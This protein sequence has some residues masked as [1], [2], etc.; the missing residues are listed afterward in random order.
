MIGMEWCFSVTPVYIYDSSS[1]VPKNQ[2]SLNSFPEETGLNT[3]P[4]ADPYFPVT[5]N[6]KLKNGSY[7]WPL[8]HAHVELNLK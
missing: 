4:V 7:K 1:I 8:L 5:M 6:L 3:Q 2:E